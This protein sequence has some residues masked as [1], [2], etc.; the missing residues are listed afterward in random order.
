MTQRDRV[1]FTVINR[2]KNK[3]S[4]KYLFE[5]EFSTLFLGKDL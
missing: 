1:A 2:K 5:E 4:V 3:L